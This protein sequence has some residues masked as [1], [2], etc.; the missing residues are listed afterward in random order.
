MADRQRGGAVIA[1]G[2]L[3]IGLTPAPVL[4]VVP[5]DGGAIQIFP[6]TINAGPG[7]QFDAHVSG[8]YV[9]YTS[10]NTVR[11]YDFVTGNDYEISP[12][13]GS[14]DQLSD[15][16]GGLITFARL[17]T[18]TFD[19]DVKLYDIA[20]GKTGYVTAD[21]AGMA[22]NPAIG[23]YTV[24]FQEEGR[25]LVAVRIPGSVTALVTS[26]PIDANPQVSPS[27]DVIVWKSCDADYSNCEVQLAAW[28]GTTWVQSSITNAPGV[29]QD[30][31][32]DGSMVVYDAARSNG[33]HIYW[34][35]VGGGAEQ[36]LDLPGTQRGASISSGVI[37][38]E[39]VNP[40]DVMADLWLYQIA[41]NRLFQVTSTPVGEVLS[42]VAVLPDGR[43]RLV[44]SGPGINGDSDVQGATIELPPAGPDYD[45][46]G[47]ASPVDAMPTI[48]QLKAGAAVPVK[49][50]LG[51][52]QGLAIFAAGY[53]K[54]QMVACDATAP[55]DGVEETVTA[56]GNSLT[57]DAATGLYAYVWKTDRA[58]AGT[59]RQLVMA[60]A[61][62]SNARA[63]FK[64]K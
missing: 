35:P 22:T 9:S 3:L 52:D 24:A 25:D 39:N 31:D 61:D 7:G 55:V 18:T 54:S 34:Q 12:Y 32:T 56:G 30:T 29:D 28:N 46:G 33:Q 41:T 1:A 49:F 11:Y 59:C 16:S 62:G 43:I 5:A 64:L 17:D 40:G 10:D 36:L 4:G 44:W 58:W 37:A 50:S 60:F 48:N 13:F 20:S 6:V 27:G 47:F 38:F 26:A 14:H 51:G 21:P 23:G 8:D 57:Y 42:D 15:V 53:P 2:L 63:T 45:F 19:V